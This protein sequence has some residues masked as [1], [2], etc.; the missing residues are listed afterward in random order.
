MKTYYRL[1]LGAKSVYAN[2]CL[3]G[4]FVGVDF[5]LHMD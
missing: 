2:E 3:Q 4:N 5:G 1:Y